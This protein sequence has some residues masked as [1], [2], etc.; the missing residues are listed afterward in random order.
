M[1]PR[2][3]RMVSKHGGAYTYLPASVGAFPYGDDFV[4]LLGEAQTALAA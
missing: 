2:I 4:R 3:G 1:L